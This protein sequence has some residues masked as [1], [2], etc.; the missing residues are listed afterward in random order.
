MDLEV[1]RIVSGS[2]RHLERWLNRF[3]TGPSSLVVTGVGVRPV[4]LAFSV[5][6]G[7]AIAPERRR[8]AA[9]RTNAKS[10][11]KPLAHDVV[12]DLGC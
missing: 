4:V 1:A 7:V 9:N 3:A 8:A 6:I 5:P 2:R 10:F 12:C 11:L